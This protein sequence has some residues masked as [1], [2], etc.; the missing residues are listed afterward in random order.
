MYLYLYVLVLTGNDSHSSVQRD[1]INSGTNNEVSEIIVTYI[2]INMYYSTCICF[3]ALV[4]VPRRYFFYR[5]VT[6]IF[7]SNWSSKR[8]SFRNSLFS[9]HSSGVTSRLHSLAET[10]TIYSNRRWVKNI[11]H[12]EIAGLEVTKPGS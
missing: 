9:R 10:E 11:H 5:I 3:G 8:S 12:E 4:K 1:L 7:V 2:Y 6:L